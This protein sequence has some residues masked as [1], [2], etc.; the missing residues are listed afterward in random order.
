MH[1]DKPSREPSMKLSHV[2]IL[3]LIGMLVTSLSVL[4]FTSPRQA[5]QDALTSN[6]SE[7]AVDPSSNPVPPPKSNKQ[8]PTAEPSTTPLQSTPE[9]EATAS[10]ITYRAS[11]FAKPI[12]S[13]VMEELSKYKNRE[14]LELSAPNEPCKFFVDGERVVG[15]EFANLFVVVGVHVVRCERSNGRVRE[16]RVD[17]RPNVRTT[18]TF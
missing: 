18:V 15:S 4:V 5:P 6:E 16:Q 12:P 1:Q 2:V 7:P 13:Q 9:P 3:S 11:R 10:N 8:E 14:I 17:V